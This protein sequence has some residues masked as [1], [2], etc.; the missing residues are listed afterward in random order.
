MARQRDHKQMCDLLAG[1]IT[2]FVEEGRQSARFMV[3]EPLAL[4]AP[5]LVTQVSSTTILYV[6][7]SNVCIPTY[8]RIL[9]TLYLSR[10]RGALIK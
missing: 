5:A 7:D 6:C 1:L 9:R 2:A 4:L 3:S 10:H 8:A